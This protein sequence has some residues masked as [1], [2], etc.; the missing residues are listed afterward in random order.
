MSGLVTAVLSTAL[1]QIASTPVNPAM[2]APPHSVRAVRAQAAIVLDGELRD[3]AW[4]QAE[5]FSQF[6]Q[7]DPNEGAPP[8]Q[9]SEVRVLFSDE[10]LYVGARLWDTA[11]DS[12]VARLARRDAQVTSDRF[13]VYLDPYHDKQTGFYFGVSAAGTQYDGTLKNDD[14]DDDTWDGIWDAKVHRDAEGWTVEIRIPYSQLRFSDADRQVWGINFD[15]EIARNNEKAFLAYTPKGSSGFV[16]RFAELSGLDHLR[17]P[18]RLEFS[19]YITS[20]AEFL[21]HAPGDPFNR[22]S[23]IRGSAGLDAKLGLGSNLTLDATVNPD[24]GQVEVDP[25]VVNLTDVETFYPEKRPFFIEGADIFEYGFG[26]ANNFWGFNWPG[27]DFFYSRRIGRPPQGGVPDAQYVDLP[28]GTTILGAAKLSGKLGHDLSIGT[29]SALTDREHARLQLPT[30]RAS[31]EIE[32]LTSYNVLRA[33]RDFGQGRQSLGLIATGTF[34]DLE[35]PALRDQLSSDAL[36]LGIDGWTF[37]DASRMWVLTGWAGASRV[38]GTRARISA[39]QQNAVHYYQRPDA[40]E[41]GLDSA[42]TSLSGY[43]GRL[44]L[45]KQ[46]GDWLVNAAF[47][48]IS[49]GFETNDLGFLS[50]TDVINSHAVVSRRW[51]KPSRL[52]RFA[53]INTGAFRVYDYAGLRTGEGYILSGGADFLNYHGAQV[54]LSYNPDRFNGRRTRGGPAMLSPGGWGGELSYNTDDRKT[55]IGEVSLSRNSYGRS[56]DNTWSGSIGLTWKPAAAVSVKFGPEYE[57]SRMGAQYVGTFAD[58]FATATFGNRYVFA[59]LDQTTLSANL[60][61]NWTFSPTLSLEVYAQPLLSSG[62]Y[63]GFKEFARPRSYDFTRYGSGGS[64]LT[65]NRDASGTV[66]DYTVDP[67]GAGAASPFSIANPDFSFVSLR[68]NAVLRWEYR[69]GST[70][71]LVW[72]QDRSDSGSDGEFEFGQSLRRLGQAKG[73]HVVAVKFSYWWHP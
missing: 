20:K 46:R 52:F 5:P 37:L 49:P 24:F 44:S 57:R 17:P 61:V 19:P 40:P 1:L 69:P 36:S 7:R 72:T 14:W 9:R 22:G 60:R 16:S 31:A 39:L 32:P 54:F 42:A 63:R 13:Y 68:G 50:R 10:A 71:Y 65:A 62:S 8:T 53:R 33:R 29:L 11:P 18:K 28:Q 25:A 30:G 51:S 70:L 56:D 21:Q 6:I 35:D 41:V 15:R 27:P 34:R 3:A 73:N 23:R 67:D 64:T 2:L 45:N 43:A 47:G 48:I 4:T 59:Y 58:S 26:G 12:I 55:V 38:S 66:V